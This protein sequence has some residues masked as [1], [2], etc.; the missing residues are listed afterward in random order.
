VSTS[1]SQGTEKVISKPY[2]DYRVPPN[3]L[4]A[5]N[6]IQL[7]VASIRAAHDLAARLNR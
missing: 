5:D 3:G 6:G 2:I 4:P 7:D 1:S